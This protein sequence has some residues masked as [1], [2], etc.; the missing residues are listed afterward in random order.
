MLRSRNPDYGPHVHLATE[1][2][3]NMVTLSGVLWCLVLIWVAASILP[4]PG[5]SLKEIAEQEE[6]RFWRELPE[7]A[8]KAA[9]DYEFFFGENPKDPTLH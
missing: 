9:R 6:R 7:L 5:L 3:E 2:E 4:F 1:E 8:K